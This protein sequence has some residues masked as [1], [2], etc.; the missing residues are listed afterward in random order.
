MPSPSA[1]P[2]RPAPSRPLPSTP[3]TPNPPPV[4]G[5]RRQSSAGAVGSTTDTT[6]ASGAA[7]PA[8]ET[9]R[10]GPAGSPG[11]G[12]ATPRR[13][14]PTFHTLRVAAVE[15][16]TDDS[17]CITFDVPDHLRD[18]YDFVHG[19]HVTLLAPQ[20]GDTVRRNYSIC[21]PAGSGVLRVGVRKLPGG[22]FSTYALERLRVGEELQVMTPSGGFHTR[23]D[24]ANARHYCA[25]VAGSGITPVVSIAA[26]TLATEP[27][28]RFTL[29]YGNRTTGSIMFLEELQDLKNRYPDRF[30]LVN[31]LSREAHEVELLHGRIDGERLPRLL[32]A[33]APADAV[34]EWFLC[35]PFD[36]VQE[37]QA[38]LRG[39]GVDPRTIHSELFHVDKVPPP[40]PPRTADDDSASAQDA[41]EVTVV[42]DGRSSTFLLRADDVGILDAA[43]RVRADAPYACKGGVCGT[44]RAR[45]VDGEVRM[46]QNYA[47][48]PDELAAGF[49]LTCQSHPV[50]DR[51]TLSF[52]Q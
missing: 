4:A 38:T 51:V 52:D 7:G 37:A 45:L 36:M 5:S 44:C 46:D 30:T 34:D 35:G 16:L 39:L 50:T 48:E 32:A 15:R 49:V 12:E 24:P 26:T 14:T 27:A 23:L 10:S 40:R 33:V 25:V 11:P 8:A 47:L 43:L 9:G 18:E 1:P 21:S 28:S 41:S 2:P 20:V 29:L 6:G 22:A 3:S 19:Q 13:R 17:V 42:L 31:V